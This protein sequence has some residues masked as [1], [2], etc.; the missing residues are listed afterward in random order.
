M[1]P[2][3]FPS[4]HPDFVLELEETLDPALQALIEDAKSAGWPDEAIWPALRSLVA[5]L[6]LAAR[7]NRKTGK[8][9]KDARAGLARGE[10]IADM[11]NGDG[12]QEIRRRD[13]QRN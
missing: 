1:K 6:E 13:R 5:H 4:G 8:A 12:G 3:R 9:I 11:G 7:E 10:R 2:P